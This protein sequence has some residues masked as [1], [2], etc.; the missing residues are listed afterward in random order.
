M[1]MAGASVTTIPASIHAFD[2]AVRAIFTNI[3]NMGHFTRKQD[4][5]STRRRVAS[6]TIC[7]CY[8]TRKTHF[9]TKHQ[10]RPFAE[11]V[12]REKREKRKEKPPTHEKYIPNADMKP[13]DMTFLT[14]RLA[15]KNPPP[16]SLS[17]LAPLSENTE[18]NPQDG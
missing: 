17:P 9:E 12:K 11:D 7:I 15:N 14:H 13:L 10:T 18:R 3:V 16:S 5:H 8:Q 6:K 2:G 1:D 4:H